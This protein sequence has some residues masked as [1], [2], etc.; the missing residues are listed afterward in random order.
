MFYSVTNAQYY[1]NTPQ[2]TPGGNPGNINWDD[3]EP[4]ANQAGW[5]NIQPSSHPAWSAQ[6]TIPFSFTFNGSTVSSYSA[7]TNGVLTFSAS[8]AAIMGNHATLPSASIP[9][10]SIC[11]WGLAYGGAQ[12]NDRIITKTFG[13]APN[14]QHWISFR[15]Y[16]LEGVSSECWTYW[17]IVLEETSN[18]IYIVDQRSSNHPSCQA[19]LTLGL[20]YSASSALMI[21]GSPNI[22]AM[23]GTSKTPYDN[24]YYEFIPG[25]RPVYDIGVDFI[26]TNQY[27][28]SSTQVEIRG[29]FKTFGTATVNSYD[30]NYSIDNGP[31]ITMSVSGVSL[32]VNSTDW[33]IHDSLWF[34]SVGNYTLKV[35]CSNINGNADQNNFNDTLTKTINVL[36]VFVPRMVLHELF[37]SANSLESK[38]SH[39]SIQLIFD[40]NASVYSYINYAMPSD[41]YSNVEGQTRATFYGADSVPDM[42]V[43]GAV[44]FDPRYY[45]QQMFIDNAG[46]AYMNITPTLTRNGNTVT[47][48]AAI[49]PFPEWVN[50]PNAMKIRIALIEK[51]TT[52]NAGTNGETIFHNVFRKMLP[53][54]G[55][56]IQNSFST[57]IFVNISETYTFA[58]NELENISNLTAIVFVQNDVTKEVYQSAVISLSNAID[59]NKTVQEGIKALYPNPAQDQFQLDYNLQSAKQVE[60]SIVDATGSVVWK[61]ASQFKSQGNHTERIQVESLAAGMYFVEVKMDK[62]TTYKKLIIR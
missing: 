4:F 43:N 48:G 47:V 13:T 53:N 36:G 12:S 10:N 37:S 39:D 1:V 58:A 5:T 44:N 56:K 57:G 60:I 32:P 42:Y 41:I 3:E 9:D 46:P 28:T 38:G 49:L 21:S 22:R 55:G 2:I 54:V 18:R 20:Q 62:N 26:Q 33:F 29:T 61:T 19:S 34:P 17:S 50:P 11:V 30:V 16:G 45:T 25:I 23:A 15:S 24:R 51:T 52:G 31:A 27:Q 40:Q 6:Q 8:P 59:E 7:A 14:R 35:W